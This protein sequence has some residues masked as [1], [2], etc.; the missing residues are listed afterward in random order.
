LAGSW[1]SRRY[2]RKATMTAAGAC[3]LVG[4][5]LVTLAVHVS[6]LIIGESAE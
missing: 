3:F 2:G 1:T 6:M 4:T 5:V